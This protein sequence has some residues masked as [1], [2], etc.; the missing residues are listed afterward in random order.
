MIR[1]MAMVGL[2]GALVATPALAQAVDPN[3]PFNDGSAAASMTAPPGVVVPGQD[4]GVSAVNRNE[5][6]ALAID[7]NT[8]RAERNAELQSYHAAVH[9]YHQAVQARR[10]TI[11]MIRTTQS[12]RDAAYARAMDAWHEQVAACQDGNHQACQA[13]TPDPA[14]FE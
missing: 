10:D 9:D 4:P 7:T 1:K 8:A 13:P 14:A 12:R 6:Q 3:Q 2:L 5:A 11:A